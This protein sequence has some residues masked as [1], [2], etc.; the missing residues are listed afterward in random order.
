[1]TTSGVN[2]A[3]QAGAQRSTTSSRGVGAMKSEDFFRIMVTELQNQDPLEPNKTSDMIGQVSQV[4][5]IELQSKLGDT[6]DSLVKQQRMNDAGSMIGK[7]V[8]A[9]I[10]VGEGQQTTTA[11]RVV[12]VHYE[13]SGSANLELDSGDFV[14][15]EKV[16]LVTTLEEAARALQEDGGTTAKMMNAKSQQQAHPLQEMWHGLGRL[17]H[18]Q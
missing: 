15:L 6:L 18:F 11:G 1:M 4:R 10:D 13:E 16:D 9:S 7:F 5:S 2:G 14:P 3:T 8:T 17:L 12:V